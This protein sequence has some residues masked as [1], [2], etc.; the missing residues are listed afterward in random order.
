MNETFLLVG[1][2]NPGTKY[3]QTRHNLG[4]MIVDNLAQ[5]L[6]SS[7]AF[8][9]KNYSLAESDVDDRNL[10]LVKPL[11]FM[12]RSGEAVA[13]LVE[14][15]SLPLG[16]L[17]IISD[18]LNL[19]FGKLRLRSRGTDGGHNGLASIIF[20]LGNEAFPRLRVGIDNGV[21][22]DAVSFVL[23]DFSKQERT[24]LPDI[25]ARATKACLHFVAEGI[26][27]TMNKFN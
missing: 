6:R 12:N 24:A 10:I 14:Q 11:T 2:G 18:D 8:G 5:E 20:C 19:P 27:H 15:F 26:V 17:L 4:F 16:H 7:F 23:S 9:E 13:H 1:L 22:T 21:F 25:I 3:A